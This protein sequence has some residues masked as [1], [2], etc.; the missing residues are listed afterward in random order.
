MTLQN[1]LPPEFKQR[2]HF[3][4]RHLYYYEKPGHITCIFQAHPRNPSNPP[5]L[6]IFPLDIENDPDTTRRMSKQIFALSYVIA[7]KGKVHYP[8]EKKTFSLAPGSLFQF[9]GHSTNDVRLEVEPGFY[10]CSLSVDGDTGKHL[11]A[12]MLWNQNNLCC[13][14]GLIPMILQ[15]Y[16]D[17]YKGIA[18]PNSN[19]RSLLKRFLQIVDFFSNISN[20]ADP[21]MQFQEEARI[22]LETHSS[23]AFKIRDAAQLMGLTYEAFRQRF[24]KVFGFSPQE[25][26]IRCRLEKA[27]TLLINHSV[28]QTA[29]L[30]EYQDPFIF[31]RQFKKYTGIPPKLFRKQIRIR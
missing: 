25:Y 16:V 2:P 12:V 19:P 23:P 30:L 26:Q 21:A 3:A 24:H 18:D 27:K 17:I 11:K 13:S 29:Q 1:S 22:I 5:L 14:V 20:K 4:T 10:E 7:G 15:E 28:K 6:Q 9:N 8:K 31:S